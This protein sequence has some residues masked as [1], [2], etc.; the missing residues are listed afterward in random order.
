[1]GVF[2]PEEVPLF[3]YETSQRLDKQFKQRPIIVPIRPP[4]RGVIYIQ[5]QNWVPLVAIVGLLGFFG[6]LAFLAYMRKS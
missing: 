1:M 5:E 4:E 6:L 2:E 3:A